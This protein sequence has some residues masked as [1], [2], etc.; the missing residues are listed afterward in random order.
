MERKQEAEVARTR[1]VLLLGWPARYSLSPPMHEAGFRAVGLDWCYRPLDVPPGTLE[2]VGS[3]L[4]LPSVVGANVT[5]PHKEGAVSIVDGLTSRARV[6][7][8]LNTIIK[9][10]DTLVGDNT[11]GVG[12]LRALA[13]RGQTPAGRRVV[14]FGAGGAAR[15]VAAALAQS[16]AREIVILNRGRDRALRLRD[17]A[18]TAGGGRLRA[19]VRPWFREDDDLRTLVDAMEGADIV[20]NATPVTRDPSSS[21]VPD[22]VLDAISPSRDCIVCDMVYRPAA[23]KLL[24]QGRSLGLRVVSGLEILFHQAIPAFEAWTGHKAP[25]EAV[26]A[27]ELALHAAAAAADRLGGEGLERAPVHDRR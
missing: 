26:E 2:A 25:S 8:A 14:L 18:L 10:G 3:V 24:L 17:V 23:T 13:K 4:R 20:V 7:G 5:I 6:A 16:G 27:M 19:E 11:D 1:V 21:P 12:L 9:T 22:E 15:G